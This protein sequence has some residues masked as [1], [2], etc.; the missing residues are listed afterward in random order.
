MPTVSKSVSETVSTGY[1]RVYRNCE[2]IL[3]RNARNQAKYHQKKAN[4]GTNPTPSAP[5][6]FFPISSAIP[7][8]PSGPAE[9]TS[10]PLGL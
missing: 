5:Y 9:Y 6:Q 1:S 10:N 4:V 2:G 3:W 7:C 8:T